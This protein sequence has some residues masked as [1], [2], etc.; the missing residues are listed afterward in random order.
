MHNA[1]TVSSRGGSRV[2]SADHLEMAHTQ[3]VKAERRRRVCEKKLPCGFHHTVIF[4]TVI[5]T[6]HSPIT[7]GTSRPSCLG[8]RVLFGNLLSQCI[9]GVLS[10]S[11]QESGNGQL[12]CLH[13]W[14]TQ[15]EFLF[16][17]V[18]SSTTSDLRAGHAVKTMRRASQLLTNGMHLQK[19]S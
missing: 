16:S 7:W 18:L 13:A 6:T 2:G 10:H 9:N 15:F 1:P 8:D 14:H 5:F 3:W 4:T 19:R 11:S 12:S 17:H